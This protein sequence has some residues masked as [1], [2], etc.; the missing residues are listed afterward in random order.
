MVNFLPLL[1]IGLKYILPIAILVG[2][3]IYILIL[4][5]KISNL[6]GDLNL[7]VNK[8]DNLEIKLRESISHNEE[9]R[10][11]LDKQ[12]NEILELSLNAKRAKEDYQNWL[13]KEDKYKGQVCSLLK[14]Q[15]NSC[16]GLKEKIN[17]MGKVKY[18][19]L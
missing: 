5:L 12:N 7:I 18:E 6:E 10:K 13:K 15:D 19:D 4:K 17:Q 14:Q 16:I 9:L 11:I 8:H 3:V 2:L 1:R